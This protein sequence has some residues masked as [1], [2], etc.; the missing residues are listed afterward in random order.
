MR[1]L[2]YFLLLPAINATAQT[3]VM[4]SLRN[5]IKK[6]KRDTVE[7]QARINLIYELLRRDPP[8]AHRLS[9]QTAKMADSLQHPRLLAGT[10]I[11]V[12]EYYRDA[13]QLDSGLYYLNKI[14]DL[15]K[16]NPGNKRINFNFLRAAGLFYKDMA[17]YNKALPFVKASIT[18]WDK[19]DETRAGQFLN[20]GNL[21]FLMGDFKKAAESHLQSLRLFEKLKNKRGQAYCMQSL[22]NN[23]FHLGQLTIAKKYLEQSIAMKE[24]LGDKRG[25]LISIVS[26]GDVYKDMNAFEKAEQTYAAGLSAA[27]ELKLAREEARVLNQFGLLYRRMQENKKA[28]ASFEQSITIYKQIGDSVTAIKPQSELFNLDLAEQAQKKTESEMLSGLNTLIRTGDRQQ[29]AIE[30]HRLSEYYVSL[31][32]FEKALYYL[33][34]HDSLHETVKGNE[35]VLQM[36]EL[37]EKYN[38]EKNEQEIALLKKDQEL[39]TAELERERANKI[40]VLIALISVV[41]IAVLLINWYRIGNRAQR[42]LEM[43]RIRNS[44][45]RDL[46]DDIGSTLSSINII[47]QLALKNANG[48]TSH[49][50][51]IAQHSH[52]LMESMSDIVWS[53]NPVNDSLERVVSKMKEFAAEILDPANINYTFEGEEALE[54]LKLDASQ[55]KNLFLIFKEAVNNTAKYSGATAVSIR[56]THMLKKLTVSIADNGKGFDVALAPSGNGLNNMKARASGLS[57]QLEIITSATGTTVQVSL[58][59]T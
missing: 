29:E 27:R 19:E 41:V 6:N 35:V 56:F 47:S 12:V 53:I 11:Y 23:Y 49:F 57:G 59:I 14:E 3:R 40:L 24:Q 50:Q 33:K 15:A 44:I 2:L 22:G 51:R 58:P 39:Q 30:Y 5:V 7:L 13:G 43:E 52:R 21:Y 45:A 4:D 1:Y 18:L 16:Q 48:S 28:R 36:K 31:K 55:R 20:L 34:K 46:H 25:V 26:L 9:L 17:E 10:Y 38:T 32:E 8:Q 54:K 37:E 42:L